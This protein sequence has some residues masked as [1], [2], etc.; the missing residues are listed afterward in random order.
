MTRIKGKSP[1][2]SGNFTNAAGVRDQCIATTAKSRAEIGCIS[3]RGMSGLP[4]R[5]AN[6]DPEALPDD[7]TNCAL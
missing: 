7:E 2:F 1:K 3:A 5:R 6:A 4:L